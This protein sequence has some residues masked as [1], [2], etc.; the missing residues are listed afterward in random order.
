MQYADFSDVVGILIGIAVVCVFLIKIT[1]EMAKDA[2]T[3]YT[4]DEE[5]HG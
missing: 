5:G 1:W 4:D 3:Y 2:S